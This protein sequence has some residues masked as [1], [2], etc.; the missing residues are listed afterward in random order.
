MPNTFRTFIVP[1]AVA[2]IA[3]LITDALGYP[4]KGMFTNPLDE[5]NAPISPLGFISTG[6]VDDASALLTDAGALWS[7]VQA[8]EPGA[9]TLADCVAFVDA[10]D[11]T[12]IAPFERAAFILDEAGGVTNAPPWVQPTGPDEAYAF[13]AVV[14]DGGR[15]WRSLK[16]NNTTRPG[17]RWWR[18]IFGATTSVYPAWVQPQPGQ[19]YPFGAGVSHVGSNW[20]SRIHNNRREP[21]SP[22]SQNQ[23]TQQEGVAPTKPG[24]GR[25]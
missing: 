10:M 19:G 5:G 24:K 12:D 25:A 17:V 1:P 4:D 7:A 18:E 14:S 6:I 22:G 15:Y 20:I 21:G 3:V 13:D 2:Q 16:E 9:L 23:W 8:G 11:L